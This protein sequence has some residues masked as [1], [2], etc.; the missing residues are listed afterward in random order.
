MYVSINFYSFASNYVRVESREVELSSSSISRPK[1]VGRSSSYDVGCTPCSTPRLYIDVGQTR[2]PIKDIQRERGTSLEHIMVGTEYGMAWEMT[3]GLA[4]GC[5]VCP[6][7]PTKVS[8]GEERLGIRDGRLGRTNKEAS[9]GA[10]DRGHG[11]RNQ[12]KKREREAG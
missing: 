3:H 9:I 10:L 5:V 2:T 4:A 6:V 11:Q 7:L 12:E 1:I 8:D